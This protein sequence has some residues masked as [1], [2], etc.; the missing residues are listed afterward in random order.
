MFLSTWPPTHLT[1][2]SHDP[3]NN[4]NHQ[5]C[6]KLK[7]LQFIKF[8][9]LLDQLHEKMGQQTNVMFSERDVTYLH[10]HIHMLS[11]QRDG[12]DKYMTLKLITLS[13]LT[14]KIIH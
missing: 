12:I 1:T 2:H 9:S 4:M 7:K 3:E 5:W 6:K 10:T 8:C 14:S 13:R 11:K